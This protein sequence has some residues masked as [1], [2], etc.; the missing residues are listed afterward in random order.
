MGC[1]RDFAIAQDVLCDTVYAI[2]D[3]RSTGRR[4]PTPPGCP[5]ATTPTVA[6]LNGDILHPV[7]GGTSLERVEHLLPLTGQLPLAVV[8]VSRQQPG[9]VAS[10]AEAQE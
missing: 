6:R 5:G 1:S 8:G 10:L 2:R 3:T 7:G 4:S 9:E